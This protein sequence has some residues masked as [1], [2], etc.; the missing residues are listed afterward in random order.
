MKVQIG[1]GQGW[2]GLGHRLLGLPWGGA[3]RVDSPWRGPHASRAAT[4]TESFI[5]HP[6][7]AG[8]RALNNERREDVLMPKWAQLGVPQEMTSA[9]RSPW[10]EKALGGAGQMGQRV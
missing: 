5:A 6:S 10:M 9:L 2:A 4:E 1:P 7:W 3:G 8:Q